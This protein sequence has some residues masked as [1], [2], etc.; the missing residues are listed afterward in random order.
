MSS[1]RPASL[2]I[3]SSINGREYVARAYEFDDSVESMKT[4]ASTAQSYRYE[5][6]RRYHAYRDGA[7]WGP[8]DEKDK[9]HQTITHH[10]FGLLLEDKLFLAP[11]Q[12]PRNV[13]D[14]GTGR[15]LWATD[16]ADQY[17]EADVIGTD[18]SPVWE[19]PVQPNLRF[20][21]DDCCS[22]W[23]YPP[24]DRERFDFIHMRGMYGSVADW[25]K[26]YKECYNHL[27]PGGWIEQAEP[28]LD[29]FSPDNSIRPGSYFDKTHEFLQACEMSMR[30][31]LYIADTMRQSLIDAGFVDVV[32]IKYKTPIGPWSSEPRMKEIGRFYR[33]YW[34]YGLEGWVMAPAT[35][36][37][38]WPVEHVREMI[39]EAREAIYD[40][41]THVYYE[42]TVVYGRKPLNAESRPADI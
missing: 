42:I 41:N 9:R 30:K 27:V 17:P 31:R 24:D 11:V 32:E 26:L 4:L 5:N 36:H 38:G 1:S 33:D 28:G 29:P 6:G 35:R 13:L 20:E 14:I 12:H 25:N 21:V 22:E 2:S 40:P 16:F 19:T 8:N 7:Y 15:G 23:A 37:L 34:D 18:L 3:D 39:A 10:L